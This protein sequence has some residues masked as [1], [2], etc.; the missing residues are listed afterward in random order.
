MPFPHPVP[1]VKPRGV[2]ERPSAKKR[3]GRAAVLA[4]LPATPRL[5]RRR[6]GL[7]EATV[8]RWLADLKAAEEAH[9]GDWRRTVGRFAAVWVAGAGE[10]APKP[11]PLSQVARD[12]ARRL[13]ER[14]ALRAE[15]ADRAAR[16][17]ALVP[18]RDPMVAALF[19]PSPRCVG[20][21]S[22]AGGAA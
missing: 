10:D 6:T 2:P 9:V 8:S 7:G 1:V 19:G 21:L 15:L 17:A 4:A 12:R 13:R 18:R 11:D 16:L 14:D 20:G 5:I 3:R 22:A